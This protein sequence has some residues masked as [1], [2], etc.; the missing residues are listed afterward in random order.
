MQ[1]YWLT[2]L[3]DHELI[4]EVTKL[5]AHERRNTADL[6]AHLAEVDARKLYAPAGYDSMY[7]WC[8][9]VLQ[10]SEDVACKRI[11]AARTARR[12]FYPPRGG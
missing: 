4:H 1:R 2:R 11:E 8:M 10:F 5:V 7:A 9:K 6:L 12:K 3:A